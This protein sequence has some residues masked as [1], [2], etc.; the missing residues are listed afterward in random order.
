[1]VFDSLRLQFTATVVILTQYDE[2]S[3]EAKVSLKTGILIWIYHPYVFIYIIQYCFS[4]LD[5]LLRYISFIGSS[6]VECV[7][8]IA[9]VRQHKLP[10]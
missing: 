5:N 7:E 10:A 1:M 2:K 4:Y 6:L 3:A 8:A 9:R